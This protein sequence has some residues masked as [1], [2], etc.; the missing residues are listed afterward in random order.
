LIENADAAGEGGGGGSGGASGGGSAGISSGPGGGG[1]SRS[2]SFSGR[3]EPKQ[4]YR[5][6]R[7]NQNPGASIE[8][9]FRRDYEI[10]YEIIWFFDLTTDFQTEVVNQSGVY[11]DLV[12]LEEVIE[13]VLRTW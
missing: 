12:Q 8:D 10:F 4:N 6:P 3:I 1:G 11:T 2:Q 5:L 13:N 9:F 7:F